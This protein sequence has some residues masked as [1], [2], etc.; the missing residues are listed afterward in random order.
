[1]YKLII[2][3]LLKDLYSLDDQET[4]F[5]KNAIKVLKSNINVY[6]HKITYVSLLKLYINKCHNQN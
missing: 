6:L 5:E 2:E 4:G 3:W 1:M